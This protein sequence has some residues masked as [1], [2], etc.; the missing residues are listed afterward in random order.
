MRNG[1]FD[2]DILLGPMEDKRRQ[3]Q[4]CMPWFDDIKKW[5]RMTVAKAARAALDRKSGDHIV[6]HS[7]A[8]CAE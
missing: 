2:K 6:N 8:K 5:T 1:G 4:P 3:G 7:Y